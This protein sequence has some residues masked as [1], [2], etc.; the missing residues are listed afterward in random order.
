MSDRKPNRLL[1][2]ERL[3]RGWSYEELAERVRTEMARCGENDTGL[4]ANTVRRWETGERRPDPRYRKHLVTILG[5]PASE[6]GLLAPEEMQLRPDAADTEAARGVM[7]AIKTNYQN[8]AMHRLTVLRGLVAIGTLPILAPLF[9]L[10]TGNG[11]APHRTPDTDSYASISRAH[12]QLYWTSPARP[13]YEASYAHTQL[14]IELIRGAPGPHRAVLATA[15]AESALLTARLALFDLQHYAVAE[16]CL[17]LALSATREAGD[18]ALAAA[19]F[20]HMAFVRIFGATPGD[21]RTVLAAALQHTWHGVSPAVRSWLHC[22]AAE[23]ESRVG[24]RVAARREIDLAVAALGHLDDAPE[25]LDFFNG[26]RLESFAG[27]AALS[28]GDNADAAVHLSRAFDGLNHRD[29]KQRSVVLAD[30]A[31][32]HADDAERAADYLTRAVNAL[33]ADWYPTGFDRVRAV[34]PILRDSRVGVELDERIRWLGEANLGGP[35]L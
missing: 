16:R 3:Q 27:Y 15:L 25:W 20:G 22:V 35:A 12:R 13:L 14:G 1:A 9:A 5:K 21:A 32:A 33:A 18:H 30:L 11:N 19:V 28:S 4:T 31:R 34:R 24:R 7:E 23:A 2:W 26:A 8:P 6:L 17:D 29:G 10:G